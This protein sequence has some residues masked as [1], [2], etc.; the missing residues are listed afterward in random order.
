MTYHTNPQGLKGSLLV[1]SCSADRTIK[2]HTLGQKANGDVQ[3]TP[4]EKIETTDEVMGFK[5]SPNGQFF[6]FSLLDQTLKVCYV[7]SMKLLL[8]LY[9]HK[10]PVLSFDISSDGNL[11][12]TGSAD[13]NLK[14]W[15]M[16]FG[17]IHKSMFLHQD[18]I[19][20]VRFVKDTHYVLTA[21]KD[22]E[23][24]LVDCYTFEEVFVFD[25]FFAEVWSIAVSSIG[26]YFVAVSADRGIRVWKQTNE[27]AFVSDEQDYRHEK[28][29]LK[30]AEK[31]FTEIDVA[32]ATQVDPFARDKVMKIESGSVTKRST[33]NIKYGDDLIYA[34]E[35]SEKFR[36]EVE[37]YAIG[38]EL[39]EA[40][41]GPE[42]ERPRPSIHFLGR[43]IYDHILLKL[44]QI[45]AADLESTLKFL[46]YTHSCALL[47]YAEHYLRNVSF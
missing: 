19:T 16:Q 30:D 40:K 38:L 33:E 21:S 22:R 14:I 4:Y 1:A 9:G 28:Q 15:G 12:A 24:K 20:C 31:E 18:S 43:T 46:N 42:P 13:K 23:V 39:Y 44:K 7:D 26:D 17:D 37:Q 32:N 3:L 8:N 47:F 36:E 5:F 41:K 34:I 29:M 45:R 35:M 2:F 25:T 10:L 27:Q 6:V 11:L